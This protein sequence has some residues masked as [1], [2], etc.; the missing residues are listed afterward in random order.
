MRQCE[1]KLSQAKTIT[2]EVLAI[3]R[4]RRVC[5]SEI[6]RLVNIGIDDG[7]SHSDSVSGFGAQVSGRVCGML[8]VKRL[9]K[10]TKKD[11]ISPMYSS[12]SDSI[13]SYQSM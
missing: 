8:S 6:E 11:L 9:R 4:E 3:Q 7:K 10:N 5:W 12:I 13:V 1:E 2:D